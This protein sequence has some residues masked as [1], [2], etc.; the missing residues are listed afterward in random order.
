M[1]SIY[2]KNN[3]LIR[4]RIKLEYDRAS[5]SGAME[6]EITMLVS[7]RVDKELLLT[8]TVP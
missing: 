8:S 1:A 6:L 5:A 7:L 4:L 2:Y 3:Q